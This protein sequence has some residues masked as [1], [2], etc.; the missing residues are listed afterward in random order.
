MLDCI[1]KE[2]QVG[3]KI[4]AADGRYAELMIGEVTGFTAKKIKLQCVLSS[5]KDTMAPMDSMK[6]PWQVFKQ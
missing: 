3:D 1:G 2:L 6:Y 4:V 5:Q